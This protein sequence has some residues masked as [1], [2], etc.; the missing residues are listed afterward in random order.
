MRVT[1]EANI[2]PSS[3]ALNLYFKTHSIGISPKVFWGD[4][5]IPRDEKADNQKQQEEFDKIIS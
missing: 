2:T 4:K 3:L 5:L 1:L